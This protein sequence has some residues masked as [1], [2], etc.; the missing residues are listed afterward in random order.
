[1]GDGNQIPLT[2]N[3]LGTIGTVMWCIQLV[4]QIWHNWKC[5]K[6]EGLPA[7]MML[8][9]AFSQCIHPG[10]S[11]ETTVKPADLDRCPQGAV[12]FGIY[13]ILQVGVTVHSRSYIHTSVQFQRTRALISNV[14]EESQ[15]PAPDPTT[16]LWLFNID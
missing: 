6:T 7:S 3:V 5:K 15:Y 1:M 8:I 14:I 9:W 4:P 12:P 13:M 11:V 10:R 2:A 16:A